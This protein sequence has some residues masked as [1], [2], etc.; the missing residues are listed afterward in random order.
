MFLFV[1]FFSFLGSVNAMLYSMS[2]VQVLLTELANTWPARNKWTIDQLLSN[3]GDVAFRISQRSS[4]KIKMTFEDYVSYMKVQHDEDPLYIFDDKVHILTMY[5]IEGHGTQLTFVTGLSD[6][7]EK[8]RLLY[9][10]S[11]V[12]L[13]CF[14][15]T[16]LMCW[17]MI[18]GLLLGG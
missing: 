14:G 17:I 8:L 9:L 18:N 16:F 10:K 5:C 12:C 13:I 6:S 15:K 1:N 3:Y 4:K 11:I 7:L 2:F